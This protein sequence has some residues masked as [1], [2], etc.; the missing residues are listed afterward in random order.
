MILSDTHIHSELSFDAKDPHTAFIQKAISLGLETIGF[1]EHVE[2]DERYSYGC[3]PPPEDALP[4]LQALKAEWQDRL[5]IL[6]G[7]EFSYLPHL[8]G[9]IRGFCTGCDE[10]DYT[11]GSVHIIELDGAVHDISTRREAIKLF[12]DYPMAV[13]ADAFVKTTEALVDSGLFSVLGHM[14]MIKRFCPAP[15]MPAMWEA[16]GQGEAFRPAL[17]NARKQ[18][19]LIGY[20]TS[21]LRHEPAEAYPRESILAMWREVGGRAVAFG[22]DAHRAEK[23]GAGRDAAERLLAQYGLAVKVPVRR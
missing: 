18:G 5:T 11:V 2:L 8:E 13:V 20:N 3:H 19:M 10:W 9:T 22:S 12:R 15:L 23:L 7:L 21:G 17:V 6:Y 1:C 4:R 14:D 16:L